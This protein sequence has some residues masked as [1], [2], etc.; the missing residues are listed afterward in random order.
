MSLGTLV[1]E[2]AEK[3]G[4]L[5]TAQCALDDGREVFAI[6]QNITSP[7]ST[8]VNKLLKT[9]CHLTTE[10]EDIIS[11]LNIPN[12]LKKIRITSQPVNGQTNDAEQTILSI[13]SQEPIHIDEIVKKSGLPGNAV[14]GSLAL[15][16][17]SGKIKNLG[18]MM[19]VLCA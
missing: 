10:A 17:L 13:L 3:S 11:V 15:L 2:G 8:G 6:P 7:N 19:F 4:A 5:I 9:G 14:S 1:I 18:S 16:E 12:N